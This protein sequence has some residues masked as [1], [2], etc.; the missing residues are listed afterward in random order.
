MSRPIFESCEFFSCKP[1]GGLGDPDTRGIRKIPVN[2]IKLSNKR[3][4][5][6]PLRTGTRK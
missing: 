5:A 4:N 3:L 6:F 2:N 1:E